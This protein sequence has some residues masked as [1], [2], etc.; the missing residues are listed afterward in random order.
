MAPAVGGLP[1]IQRMGKVPGRRNALRVPFC[2][3]VHK[4]AGFVWLLVDFAGCLVYSPIDISIG[5]DVKVGV[6]SQHDF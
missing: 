4:L 1:R 3:K 2:V 5:H 6:M